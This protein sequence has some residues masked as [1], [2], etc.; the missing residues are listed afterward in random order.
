MRRAILLLGL[1]GCG[2]ESAPRVYPEVATLTEVAALP[3]PFTPF[4]DD[5]PV[6]T[7][8]DWRT[9]RVPELQDLFQHYV[10]GFRPAP[11]AVTPTVEVEDTDLGDGILYREVRLDLGGE[12]PAIHLA[13]FRPAAAS[14]PPVLLALNPC[15]NHTLI[16][17]P[18][19]R[20]S[21]AWT[22]LECPAGRGGRAE[23]WPIAEIV[24]RGYALATFHESDVDPDD[25][26][27]DRGLD[28][29]HPHFD[30]GVGVRTRWG[31][32]MA[33]SWGLSRAVDYLETAAEVDGAR[34]LVTGHSRRGKAALLAAAFDARIAAA[35]P[36]QSGLV[37][38]S[39]CRD[40]GGETVALITA[41]FPNWFDD[42]FT[43][44]VG[45]ETRLPV[46][47]H[48]LLAL[49]APR[50]LLVTNGEA[51]AHADPPGARRAVEAARPVY[52]LLGARD[53]IEWHARPG[54]HSLTPEDWRTFMAFADRAL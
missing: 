14:S 29:V 41:A 33:W 16:D 54:G 13:V 15:G 12:A 26:D 20:E 7:A 45:Q 30:P 48:L 5:R 24:G 17:H 50:P 6:E 34:L 44:F 53:A 38:A 11:A 18:A 8:D 9:I 3:D 31:R 4:F 35:A 19:V 39:P 47:Q 36:H 21:P 40:P 37:G 43:E 46:D 22:R 10:Y 42:V 52:E 25:P 49:V 32:I 27:D 51:D 1:A 28:G 23:R 2:A